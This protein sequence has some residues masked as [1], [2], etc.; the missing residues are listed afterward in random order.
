MQILHFKSIYCHDYTFIIFS[1]VLFNRCDFF[2]SFPTLNSIL[3]LWIT[4][5]LS[6]LLFL[7]L[8]TSNQFFTRN[9][10]IANENRCIR[11]F[12]NKLLF[13]FLTDMIRETKLSV[14]ISLSAWSNI[15]FIEQNLMKNHIAKNSNEK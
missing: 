3:K 6:S 2:H 13:S 5:L 10:V 11:L 7:W 1:M 12:N 8:N 14:L 4:F 15:W 9:F